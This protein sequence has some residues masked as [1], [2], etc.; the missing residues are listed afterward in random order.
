VACLHDL[1]SVDEVFSNAAPLEESRLV[2]VDELMNHRL[3]PLGHPFGA[4]L[5]GAV[6]KRDGPVALDEDGVALLG[7]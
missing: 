3:Q 4:N 2:H 1:S 6:L 7:K 5:G